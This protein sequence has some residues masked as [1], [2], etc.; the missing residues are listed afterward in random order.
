MDKAL[1]VLLNQQEEQELMQ[2]VRVAKDTLSGTALTKKMKE[3][4]KIFPEFNDVAKTFVSKGRTGDIYGKGK[5][6]IR[7]GLK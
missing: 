6:T 2:M 7:L 1:A 3:I 4:H 5:K